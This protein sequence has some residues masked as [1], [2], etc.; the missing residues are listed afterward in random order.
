[1]ID[2]EYTGNE[3]AIVGIACALEGA[4]NKTEFWEKLTRGEELIR[5]Y[6]ISEL[7]EKGVS[8]KLAQD[9]NF[10]GV[11][12]DIENQDHFDHDFFNY[13]PR[14]ARSMDP[15]MR[16]F[17][18]V[19]W[20]G[21]EDAGIN[22]KDPSA[23]IGLY[24]GAGDNQMW[25]N[26][27]SFLKRDEFLD[28][29]NLD[30][31]NNKDNI[32]S[33]V[34]YKLGLKGP[35]ISVNTGCSTSLVAVHIAVRNLLLGECNVAVAGGIRISNTDTIGYMYEEGNILSSDGHCRPFSENSSGTIA[36]DGA[37]VVVLKR[38]KDAI[39]DG[40]NIYAIIKGSAINNDGSRKVGFTAPS[41]DG[42]SDCIKLAHKVSRVDPA[43]ITYIETH[44]TATNLGDQVE[45]EGISSGF[46]TFNASLS[47]GSVKSNIGHCD[48]AAG[49]IGIIKTALCLKNR[50]LVPTINFQGPNEALDLNERGIT[51]NTE[52]KDWGAEKDILRGAISSF[53]I[54]GTN[55]HIVVEDFPQEEKPTQ[56][57]VVLPL[58]AKSIEALDQYKL[59]LLQFLEKTE[60]LNLGNIAHTF[61][62]G[63]V[64]FEF[65]DAVI[66]E[67]IDQLKSALLLR[68]TSYPPISE[69]AQ[70]PV[71]MFSGQGAQYFKM[72]KGL[73][74]NNAIVR[75]W[76]DR[77]LDLLKEHGIADGKM[78]L[79]EDE[80]GEKIGNTAYTQPLLFI[81]EYALFKAL[82]E[83]GIEP[84]ISI[85]HSVG[86]YVAACLSGVF[87]FEDGIKLMVNRG[88]L[89]NET[90]EG[91]MISVSMTEEE[92]RPFLNERLS[93]A[94]VN[95]KNNCVISGY[96]DAVA[97]L[98][99]ELTKKGVELIKLK[100]SHAFHSPTVD[101]IR[102]SFKALLGEIQLSAP[103]K[104]FISNV[105]G[106]PI[107]DS[108]ATD[109]EYWVKH[110]RC[111]V[112]FS[113]GIQFLLDSDH[114]VFIEVGPGKTLCSFV[115][116]NNAKN[117]KIHVVETTRHPKHDVSD[118]YFFKQAIGN[119]WK[120]GMTIHWEKDRN[121]GV[122]KIVSLPTYAFQ[123]SKYPVEFNLIKLVEELIGTSRNANG[124]VLNKENWFNVS[125]WN[126]L[127]K[128]SRKS[129][130]I[131]N[132]VL[133]FRKPDVSYQ[134]PENVITID[135]GKS[136]VQLSD[137]QYQLNPG[138][139]SGFNELFDLLSKN[140]RTIDKVI[141][142]WSNE[143][144]SEGE[145][146]LQTNFFA[147]LWLVQALVKRNKNQIEIIVVTE[148]GQQVFSNEQIDVSTSSIHGLTMVMTQEFPFLSSKIIDFNKDADQTECALILRKEMESVRDNGSIIGYRNG[149]GWQ[150]SYEKVIT[151]GFETQSLIGKSIV[152]IG[153]MGKAGR[154]LSE[155][156][157]FEHK[158]S[159]SII[160]RREL[161]NLSEEQR[162]FMQ[163]HSHTISYY[164]A[165]GSD[166]D[167]LKEA[168]R[169]IEKDKGP[170]FG[171]LHL[172]GNVELNDKS[173]IQ[174]MN[175]EIYLTQFNSKIA[176]WLNI[177]ELTKDNADLNFVWCSS[178]LA[179]VMGGIA[180][181][182]YASVNEFID[183]A[184]LNSAG[185]GEKTISVSLDGIA[186]SEDEKYPHLISTADLCEIFDAT[187]SLRDLGH[188]LISKTE[189]LPRIEK[190]IINQEIFSQTQD[191]LSEEEL[192]RVNNYAEM[193]DSA[194]AKLLKL[195]RDIF[196]N[197]EI[198]PDSNF[199]NVG[200]NSLSAMR[201]I[202]VYSKIF[203]VKLRLEQVLNNPTVANHAKLINESKEDTFMV[204][205]KAEHKDLYL[206]TDTQKR[207]WLLS[208]TELGDLKYHIQSNMVFKGELNLIALNES[209]K[210]VIS[211][212]EIMRT[213]FV[214][215][216]EKEDVFQKINPV[217]DSEFVQFFDYSQVLN[218]EEVMRSHWN[219]HIDIPYNLETGPLMRLQVLKVGEEE[220]EIMYS[221]HHIISDGWSMELLKKEVFEG[222]SDFLKNGKIEQA[223]LEYQYKDYSEWMQEYAQSD[224]FDKARSFYEEEFKT[225]ISSIEFETRNEHTGEGGE[226]IIFNLHK[227]TIKA[228]SELTDVHGG[229]Q[230][231]SFAA[232]VGIAINH[233]TGRDQFV[234]GS[235]FAGRQHPALENQMGAY[236][237]NLPLKIELN[238]E[239]NFQ[240]YYSKIKD[241]FHK[242]MEYQFFPLGRIIEN[243]ETFNGFNVLVEY[244]TGYGIENYTNDE[245]IQNQDIIEIYDKNVQFDLSLELIER[246]ND[247]LLIINYK[248]ALFDRESIE[249][250]KLRIENIIQF[251]ESDLHLKDIDPDRQYLRRII[252]IDEEEF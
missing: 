83:I 158:A 143:L 87:S 126:R 177:Q 140:K 240:S 156:L 160:A 64:P 13:L 98:I 175:E 203:G 213:T 208:Q 95:A 218:I 71:F 206:A 248:K 168:F 186:Y 7:L 79:F 43:S 161:G 180:F 113:K 149:N 120:A 51:V 112:Q 10:V 32:A 115:R 21:L 33:L 110:L 229:T 16:F 220:Y 231:V 244:Q 225:E 191:E 144:A 101:S 84:S 48:T 178:S 136:F 222:Y 106:K 53:G 237:N 188:V 238:H 129:A 232:V 114:D 185:L 132:S 30:Y 125:T 11:S 99:D 63:R 23:I 209:V 172:A 5:R 212:H 20:E 41:I 76:I 170:I 67:N 234:F 119:L 45:I 90:P 163:K 73:Y 205:P 131:T 194:E 181:S 8:E 227:D 40:N 137:D 104:P 121:E 176:T 151:D 230:Y 42:Q 59:K 103:L 215:D 147:L 197:E 236:I 192:E 38:L 15:Q 139:K 25:K 86:E 2:R 169:K 182:A 153:G 108:E 193:D 146:R 224:E 109:P 122:Y 167:G 235:S 57:I 199:F 37:G 22:V 26:Y 195:W 201:L 81:F 141:Y 77:G 35:A 154:A 207:F 228:L 202:M 105:T 19:V 65:R 211:R 88:V 190:Y 102:N 242:L 66:C 74:D 46:G 251:V 128:V 6:S 164:Q 134:L 117:K 150:K 135:L 78:V 145:N 49:V 92:I 69:N 246:P 148:N 250:L 56:G 152:L 252:P 249:A 133:H 165:D 31:L 127:P 196:E 39:K 27:T 60:D 184:G 3:I 179:T 14:E 204:I 187:F 89:M 226:E 239:M 96:E 9:E 80:S 72:G 36:T 28:D 47:I 85:G 50:K 173:T 44:G 111:E 123:E 223:E 200:G 159:V 34:S 55:A 217:I 17:H 29:F 245:P 82:S 4:K 61:Q 171:I 241:R 18:K 162:E 189:L 142:E 183:T 1:M 138:D 221:L 24:A 12:S 155:H 52:Y 70:K 62:T 243:S 118:D 174:S 75:I 107:L 166:K 94:A 116:L 130:P 124:A 233:L 216:A 54:G 214:Y 210:N 91:S 58:S 157:L 198:H 93:I 68:G 219:K 247:T 100:T 97:G